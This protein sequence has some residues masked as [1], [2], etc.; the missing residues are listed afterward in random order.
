MRTL[1]FAIFIFG[2]LSRQSQAQGGPCHPYP[3][4][5][6]QDCLELIGNSLRNDTMLDF[7]TNPVILSLRNCSIV[8]KRTSSI[9][10][11]VSV[12]TVARMALTQIGQCALSD[13][14][15]ISGSYTDEVN[16][17]IVCYLYPGRQVNTVFLAVFKEC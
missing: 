5:V 6:A 15:S 11:E 9:V 13:Y 2:Y 1:S 3:G 16:G 10:P 8:T 14:G 12:D 7:T 4:A 17:I